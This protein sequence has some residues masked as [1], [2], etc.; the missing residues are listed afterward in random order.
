MFAAV[1]QFL[2]ML[3]DA[4]TA[5]LDADEYGIRISAEL[6]TYKDRVKLAADL[7]GVKE[8]MDMGGR[9]LA[10]LLDS[11]P[12]NADSC[13]R[14]FNELLGKNAIMFTISKAEIRT[15]SLPLLDKLAAVASDC[16]ANHCDRRAH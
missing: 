12:S 2:P 4:E 5:Q 13:Q 16:D 6:A 15:R 3:T 7:A 1:E 14:K 8:K 10:W 9:D 11:P